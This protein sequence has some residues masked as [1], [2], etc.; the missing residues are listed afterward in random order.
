[1]VPRES[2]NHKMRAGARSYWSMITPFRKNKNIKELSYHVLHRIPWEILD[3]VKSDSDML[4]GTQYVPD[5]PVPP[6][7]VEDVRV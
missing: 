6:I 4:T 1:M 3:S 2:K 7:P 5:P